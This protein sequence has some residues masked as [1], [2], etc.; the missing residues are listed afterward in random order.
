MRPAVA[1]AGGSGR[2]CTC[3]R[4][5]GLV[6]MVV[7]GGSLCVSSLCMVPRRATP[8]RG[9][10]LVPRTARLFQRSRGHRVNT[11]QSHGG[12]AERPAVFAAMNLLCTFCT[13]CRLMSA[14]V[15]GRAPRG[16]WTPLQLKN[17]SREGPTACRA[18]PNFDLKRVP[19]LAPGAS[20][21]PSPRRLSHCACKFTADV[22]FE[23]GW[24]ALPP[25]ALCCR[26]GVPGPREGCVQRLDRSGI[27]A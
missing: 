5:R 23:V 20:C 13:C 9:R 21:C 16:L 27:A 11:V 3:A 15:L 1:A 2:R 25:F 17:R 8:S 22:Q 12:C 10:A 14:C 26:T 7:E 6:G 18:Q 4:Q 19:S 24:S